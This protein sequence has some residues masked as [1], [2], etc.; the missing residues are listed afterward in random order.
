[1]YSAGKEQVGV[2]YD[3]KREESR[4]LSEVRVKFEVRHQYILRSSDQLAEIFAVK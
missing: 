1:M 4:N 3:K 2:S